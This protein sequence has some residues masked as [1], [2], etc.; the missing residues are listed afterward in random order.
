ME[1]LQ[2]EIAE[3]KRKI[4]TNEARLFDEALSD[5]LVAILEEIIVQDTVTLR[6]MF[7]QVAQI[8]LQ[9]ALQS[10]QHAPAPQAGQSK[11]L[12]F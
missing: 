10:Q 12:I 5:A 6:V 8:A 4:E 3:L 7:Q 2:G 1:F 11:C 9:L